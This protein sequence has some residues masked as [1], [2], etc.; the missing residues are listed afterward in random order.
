MRTNTSK[1]IVIVGGDGFIGWPLA[2]QLKEFGHNII[3]VDNLSR[4]ELEQTISGES[5]C[6]L[7]SAAIR[8]SITNIPYIIADI[9]SDEGFISLT[10]LLTQNIDI[11]VHLAQIRSAPHSM[12]SDSKYKYSSGTHR[13]YG[14][15]WV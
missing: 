1:N 13:N 6:P 15:I 14:G 8:S 3:I 7:S 5:L 10:S 2:V 9:I 4:R 11:V 12:R